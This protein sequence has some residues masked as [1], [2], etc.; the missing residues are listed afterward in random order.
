VCTPFR[1]LKNAS[2]SSLQKQRIKFNLFLAAACTWTKTLLRLQVWN[3]FAKGEQIMRAADC[4]TKRGGHRCVHSFLQ[5][6]TQNGF[7]CVSIQTH[8]RNISCTIFII[9]LGTDHGTVVSTQAQG[10]HINFRSQFF[11]SS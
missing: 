1:L 3:L 10:R 5:C 11:R 4:Q 9:C 2:Q 8:I 7:G 6:F